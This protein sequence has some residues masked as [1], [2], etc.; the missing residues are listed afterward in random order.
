VDTSVKQRVRALLLKKD[1][2]ELTSLCRKERRFWHALKHYLYET[3]ENLRWPAIKAVAELMKRWWLDGEEERVREYIRGLFWQLN[4]ESGGFGW[5]AP[6]VIAETIVAIPEL[7]EQYSSI[8]LGYAL[9][10]QTLIKS[11]LW[12]I[13]RLGKRINR[14]FNYFQDTIFATFGS[15]DPETLGLVAWAMGEVGVSSAIAYITILKGRKEMV[16][17]YIDGFFLEKS[18]GDWSRE[19]IEKIGQ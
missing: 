14:A 8:M 13:G 2:N 6:E 11:S 9:E 17:I 15:N 12:A 3:D 5:S 19:A 18:L 7:L 16:R 1:Y 4:E 10:S